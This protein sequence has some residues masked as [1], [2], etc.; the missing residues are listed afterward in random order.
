MCGHPRIPRIQD[1]ALVVDGK[2]SADDVRNHT[3]TDPT[4][5]ISRCRHDDTAGRG[6]RPSTLCIFSGKQRQCAMPQDVRPVSGCDTFDVS[7]SDG[8]SERRPSCARTWRHGSTVALELLE[9]RMLAAI[10]P[11]LFLQIAVML[12]RATD[13]SINIAI[14]SGLVVDPVGVLSKYRLRE[15][16]PL[17]SPATRPPGQHREKE[18]KHAVPATQSRHTVGDPRVGPNK[19]A[20]R[21]TK[22]HSQPQYARKYREYL[23]T[24]RR[25]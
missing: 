2:C 15:A 18:N 6:G 25:L 24:R 23:H 5:S 9:L 4:T 11:F 10:S 12:A 17:N 16:L 20:S 13:R 19:R 8:G 7:M 22:I 14:P 21:A 1:P 3:E